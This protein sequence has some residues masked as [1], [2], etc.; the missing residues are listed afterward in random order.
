MYIWVLKEIILRLDPIYNLSLFPKPE[1]SIYPYQDLKYQIIM[2]CEN[3]NVFLPLRGLS[4][5]LCPSMCVCTNAQ[6]LLPIEIQIFV[7]IPVLPLMKQGFAD[8]LIHYMRF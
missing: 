2:C 1:I 8:V 5:F 6:T 7:L 4:D 3:K